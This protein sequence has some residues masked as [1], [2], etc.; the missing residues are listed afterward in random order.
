MNPPNLKGKKAFP[1]KGLKHR[2]K[3]P[4]SIAINQGSYLPSE[5]KIQSAR[6]YVRV[7]DKIQNNSP[8]LMIQ[9]VTPCSSN[10]QAQAY[11]YTTL[12][13][14]SSKKENMTSKRNDNHNQM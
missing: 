10:Q 9:S 6:P 14:V 5:A 4:L 11:K 3:S 7:Y 12:I 1:D 13:D 2:T 8:E